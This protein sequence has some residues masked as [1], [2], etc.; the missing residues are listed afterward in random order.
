VYLLTAVLFAFFIFITWLPG[1]VNFV[2]NLV[3]T[4]AEPVFGYSVATAVISPL[5]GVWNAVIFFGINWRM[6]LDGVANSHRPSRGING[7][8]EEPGRV[9][10]GNSMEVEDRDTGLGSYW[11]RKGPKRESSWDFL[12]VGIEPRR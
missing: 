3:S 5:Q 1:T 10:Q 6:M 7:L 8:L 12:D 2:R 4:N 9:I 11:K